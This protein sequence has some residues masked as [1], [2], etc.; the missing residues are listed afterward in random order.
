MS[1]IVNSFGLLGKYYTID[2][3]FGAELSYRF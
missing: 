1:P 2:R 3:T